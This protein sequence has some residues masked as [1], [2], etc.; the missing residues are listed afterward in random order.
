MAN[1]GRNISRSLK[2]LCL[3]RNIGILSAIQEKSGYLLRQRGNERFVNSSLTGIREGLPVIL[4]ETKRPS[5]P[6]VAV[7]LRCIYST[8]AGIGVPR[9]CI[10]PLV[11]GQRSLM[12]AIRVHHKEFTIRL[13]NAVVERCLIFES[14]T[15]AAEENM[16][17]IWRPYSVC[18]ISPSSGQ[19]P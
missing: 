7:Q 16:L 19:S 8:R 14:E 1:G 2:Q 4:L 9:R 13:R 11:I 10:F 5:E 6:S 3:K 18:I 17:S 12:G 15:G